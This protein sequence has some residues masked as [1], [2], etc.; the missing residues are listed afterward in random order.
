VEG[1]EASVGIVSLG[2]FD[3]DEFGPLV[4]AAAA[5]VSARLS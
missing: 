5:E 3:A 2:D 4:V 1:L